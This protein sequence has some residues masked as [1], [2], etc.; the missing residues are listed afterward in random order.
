MSELPTH[1]LKKGTRV[2]ARQLG[3]ADVRG[4]VTWAGPSR[5]G[6]GFRYG[7]K[8]DDGSQH[9]VDEDG[10]TP[11]QAAEVDPNSIQKGSRVRVTSGKHAGVEGDVY[12]AGAAGRFGV[13][14]DD[15]E[16][17]WFNLDELERI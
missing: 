15:E 5:Y 3:K 13:R 9:W 12:I 10:V 8:A 11:E 14:D 17:Y 2:L 1:L 6:G 7:I 4:K 16:T